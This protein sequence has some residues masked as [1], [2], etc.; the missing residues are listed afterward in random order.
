MNDE[1]L[2]GTMETLWE[3]NEWQSDW[4]VNQSKMWNKVREMI[5]A[6]KC[7][8]RLYQVILDHGNRQNTFFKSYLFEFEWVRAFEVSCWQ[9]DWDQETT[10]KPFHN[11]LRDMKH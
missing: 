3:T 9:T 1:I 7:Q 11:P 6:G 8:T 10:R 2:S 4:I 5:H